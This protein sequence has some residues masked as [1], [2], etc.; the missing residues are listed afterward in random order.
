MAQSCFRLPVFHCSDD[1]VREFL[2]AEALRFDLNPFKPF[3]SARALFKAAR[4]RFTD[5]RCIDVQFW[6][7]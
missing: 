1:E 5:R 2:E 6:I 7:H 4:D 3:L